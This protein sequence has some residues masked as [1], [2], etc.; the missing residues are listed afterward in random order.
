MS[1]PTSPP[2]S[3]KIM[4]LYHSARLVW[5]PYDWSPRSQRRT[6][7]KYTRWMYDEVVIVVWVCRYD[8]P[9][10]CKY[11]YFKFLQ[12]MARRQHPPPLPPTPPEAGD[13]AA[14]STD[15]LLHET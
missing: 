5:S 15:T 10:D 9:F 8:M 4:H 12:D 13:T 2:Y 11:V 14:Q 3:N 6:I 1:A 7:E